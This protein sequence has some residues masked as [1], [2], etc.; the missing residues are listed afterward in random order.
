V[1]LG[2]SSGW[3]LN[4]LGEANV[5]RALDRENAVVLGPTIGALVTPALNR[6]AAD[7]SVNISRSF[8]GG[9]S[10]TL[11]KINM[12]DLSSKTPLVGGGAREGFSHLQL[13]TP[14][15]VF[16]PPSLL[17]VIGSV[18]VGKVIASGGLYHPDNM[19]QRALPRRGD[20]ISGFVGL[21]V[22]IRPGGLPGFQ[23]VK[24]FFTTRDQTDYEDIGLVLVPGAVVGRTDGGTAVQYSFQQYL[25]VNRNR[26]AG[27]ALSGWGVFGSVMAWDRNSSPLD[28]TVS[29]GITGTGP[30]PS[31]PADR[32]GVGVFTINI[33]KAVISGLLPVA[34]LVNERGLEAFYTF[35]LSPTARLTAN[36]Q[37]IDPVLGRKNMLV[38]PGLRL[39]MLI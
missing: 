2:S 25:H 30:L 15:T 10:L 4:I 12:I 23:T 14:V 29:L 13:S 19:A 22:P 3:T 32:F 35:A 27:S 17:G 7:L 20:G 21:T 9:A 5:G 37:V 34:T 36:V 28:L 8:A 1:P 33:N 26:P 38:L 11:G 24:F 39:R 18:P 16:L 31:R 6:S